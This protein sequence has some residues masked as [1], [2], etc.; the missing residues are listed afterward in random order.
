EIAATVGSAPLGV[1]VRVDV[2]A[3]LASE[4]GCGA[5]VNVVMGWDDYCDGGCDDGNP[6]TTGACELGV[7]GYENVAAGTSC[8]DGLACTA[9]D[10]CDGAGTCGGSAVDCSATVVDFCEVPVC[11]EAASGCTGAPKPCA[12]PYFY[13]VVNTPTGI[14]S[15]RCWQDPANRSLHC[16]EDDNGVLVVGPPVCGVE[17]L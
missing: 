11:T 7:C 6:C 9:G 15:I 3:A 16:D 12:T 1:G 10:V 13:A 4:G 5:T 17:G 8:Q 14:G 2:L